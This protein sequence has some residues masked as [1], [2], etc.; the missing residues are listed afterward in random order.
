[1]RLAVRARFQ[2]DTE[3]ATALENTYP[4]K[5]MDDSNDDWGHK[6]GW[7]GAVLQEVRDENREK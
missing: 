6:K 5:L 7:L 4:H 2:C 1:M 3:F